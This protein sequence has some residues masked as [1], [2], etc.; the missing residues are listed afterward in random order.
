MAFCGNC[1][2]QV[3]NEKFCPNCGFS[4][5]VDNNSDIME[6][7]SVKSKF[8]I[9]KIMGIVVLVATVAIGVKLLFSISNEPCDWCGNTPSVSY[10]M[11]N[12]SKAYVC[13]K[14]SKEC[15]FCGNN[16]TKHYENLLG[17]VAFVCD[18]CYDKISEH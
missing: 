11:S 8:T 6:Q 5:D 17:T 18:D 4:I 2:R 10:S 12:G 15:M 7:K 14:C 1:G 13:K 16:A 9:G 3:E